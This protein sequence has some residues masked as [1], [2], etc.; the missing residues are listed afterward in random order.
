M[1]VQKTVKLCSYTL[2]MILFS[3]L[4]CIFKWSMMYDNSY[5]KHFWNE[6]NKIFTIFIRVVPSLATLISMLGWLKRAPT[7]VPRLFFESQPEFNRVYKQNDFRLDTQ[8]HS[9]ER[10][11]SL[12]GLN[13]K[14]GWIQNSCPCC[15]LYCWPLIMVHNLFWICFSRIFIPIVPRVIHVIT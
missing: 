11:S 10:G 7:L 3:L 2:M 15:P 4:I 5:R 14:R 9:L 8:R 6:G 1:P 12:R 13:F